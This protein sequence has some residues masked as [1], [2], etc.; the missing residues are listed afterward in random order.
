MSLITYK[1]NSCTVCK[2][3]VGEKTNSIACSFCNKWC[4]LKCIDMSN[5]EFKKHV[6]D[7]TIRWRCQKCEIFKCDKCTKVIGQKQNKL[8]CF[9]CNGYFHTQCINSLI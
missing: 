8:F 7:P 1:F 9:E 2:V 6:E 3:S 4:H 5:D